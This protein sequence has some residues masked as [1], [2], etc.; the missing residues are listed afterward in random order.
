MEEQDLIAR[1]FKH[2]VRIS[3]K[4][5]L[6]KGSG[7]PQPPDDP[8]H[9]MAASLRRIADAQS[10]IADVHAPAPSEKVG[11]NYVAGQL[12]C[13]VTYVGQMARDGK[14]PEDCVV[15]GSGDGKPWKFLRTAIDQWIASR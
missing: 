1:Y 2:V 8:L 12:G 11:T 6:S 5:E 13:T 9:D 7:L 15:P 4:A 14:I 10:R 3:K